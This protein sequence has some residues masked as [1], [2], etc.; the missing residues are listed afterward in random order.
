MPLVSQRKGGER[1]GVKWCHYVM[2]VALPR[3]KE[4]CGTVARLPFQ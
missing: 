1:E 2:R 4:F 3:T